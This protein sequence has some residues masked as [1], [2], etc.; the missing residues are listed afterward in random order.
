MIKTV[1]YMPLGIILISAC[2]FLISLSLVDWSPVS[3]FLTPDQRGRIFMAHREYSKAAR[4]FEDPQ[5]RGTAQYRA[6]DFKD[7]AASFGQDDS[8]EAFYN[9][10]NAMVMLGNYDQ[11]IAGY[12]DVLTRRPGW[13]EAADNLK[14]AEERKKRLNPPDEGDTGTGGYLPPDK[15]V[16]DK[17]AANAPNDQK[18]T[19]SGGK[20]RLTEWEVQ[21]MWLR[22]VQTQP[23][24]FLRAKF[25][26]QAAQQDTENQG[27]KEKK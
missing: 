11:A 17:K 22:K 12:R 9:R 4:V 6:G 8:L 16:F 1:K 20:K 7:A 26:Y 14:L 15:V 24:D 5:Q 21:A 3:L 13:K 27:Q 23:A 2:A 25:S 10:A 18:E 19:V